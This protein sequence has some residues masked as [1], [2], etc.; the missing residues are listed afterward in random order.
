MKGIIFC[1]FIEMVEQRFSPAL[2]DRIISSCPLAT[3]GAYTAV[4][5]YDHREMVALVERL[6]ETTDI[7]PAALLRSFGEYLLQRFATLYPA[8]FVEQRSTFELLGILDNKIHLEVKKLYPEA[9]LPVF[10]HE[11]PDADHM[12]LW[13]SSNRPF[14][15]LAE[16][17]ISGC[18][19][20]FGEHITLT[21]EDL[22]CE[23]GSRARF[24]LAR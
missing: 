23:Q 16:G 1:E 9:E 24:L 20:Y 22:P 4:G 15:D 13:Y 14:A 17:L 8:Y 19:A 5:N 21:R 6:S 2:A 3:G 10:Q 7:S 12:V 18:I 11:Y